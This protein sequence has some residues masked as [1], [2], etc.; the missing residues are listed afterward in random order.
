MLQVV[1]KD[2]LAAREVLPEYENL[3]MR[4]KANVQALEAAVKVLRDIAYQWPDSQRAT[5]V[6]GLDDG[7]R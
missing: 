1:D 7:R 4:Y 2:V 6:Q 5:P 3:L